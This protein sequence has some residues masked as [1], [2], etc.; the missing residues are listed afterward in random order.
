MKF[1]NEAQFIAATLTSLRGAVDD[2]VLVDGAYELYYRH[3][4]QFEPRAKP[5]ST[6]GSLEIIQTIKD[7]PPTRILHCPGEKPWLNQIVKLNAMIDAVPEGEWFLIID[8]DE[9]ILGDF[10]AALK[11]IQDSGCIVGRVPL[12]NLGADVDRLFYF[13][14]PRIFLKYRGMHYS[15]THWQLRDTH[16]RFMESDYPIFWSQQCVIAHFKMLK[17]KR[18]IE[19]HLKYMN[20]VRARGWLEP[21]R[22]ELTKN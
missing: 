8:G 4:R 11:E 5:Y 10:P 3:Y 18:R 7:L 15:G 21:L 12:V 2:I 20:A 19:P 22:E 16:D 17:S 9:M 13:W 1:Y 6:D 14:H